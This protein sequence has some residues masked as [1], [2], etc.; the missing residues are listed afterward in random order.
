MVL[1][2]QAVAK[3]TQSINFVLEP[4]MATAG[5]TRI[6]STTATSSLPVTF[7]S[8]NPAVATVSGSTLT[9]I[10]AGSATITATQAGDSQYEAA[11]PVEQTLTVT[12][13]ASGFSTWNGNSS[14]MTPELLSKYAI[15][16]ATNSAATGEQPFVS[17]TASTFSLT[18]VVRT[19][20]PKLTITPRATTS[21]VGAWDYPVA[22][23][24][25]AQSVNQANVAV[26]C[27]R[28]VFTLDRSTNTKIFIR[29][30]T[31]YTP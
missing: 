4:G 3:A 27:E 16:G 26:G 30:E 31:G 14:T 2:V 10:A 24:G 17:L 20:D 29:L 8:S 9:I 1:T 21:L 6:L 25:A 11:V 22:T 15:G 7:T 28:K 13:A 18:A 12:S 19:D 23:A 5:T